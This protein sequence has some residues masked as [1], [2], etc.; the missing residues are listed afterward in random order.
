MAIAFYPDIY[1][2]SKSQGGT[3]RVE[4]S[5]EEYQQSEEFFSEGDDEHSDKEDSEAESDEV[6]MY[7]LVSGQLLNS[8]P[9][10]QQAEGS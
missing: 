9:D 4:S 10:S 8:I 5:D 7:F 6:G 2:Y 1:P 3:H